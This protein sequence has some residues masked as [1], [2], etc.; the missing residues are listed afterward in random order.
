MKKFAWRKCRKISL[1]AIFSILEHF[2]QSFCA[3]FSSLF[4]VI[5]LAYNKNNNNND[6]D[7]DDD[8]NDK[9][10]NNN[11]TLIATCKALKV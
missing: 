6:E 3:K 8:D 1:K 2:L 4:H 9:N 7:D 5:S 11:N 10:N